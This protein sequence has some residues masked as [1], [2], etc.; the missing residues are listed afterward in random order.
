[1]EENDFL[2]ECAMHRPD[3]TDTDTTWLVPDSRDFSFSGQHLS[4]FGESW[5]TVSVKICNETPLPLGRNDVL[6]QVSFAEIREF[7]VLDTVGGEV[8]L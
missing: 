4:A 5:S 8:G 6:T 7:G 1:M 3:D 2:W